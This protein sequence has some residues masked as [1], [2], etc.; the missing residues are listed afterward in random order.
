MTLRSLQWDRSKLNKL[1]ITDKHSNIF[2]L[3][4]DKVTYGRNYKVNISRAMSIGAYILKNNSEMRLYNKHILIIARTDDTNTKHTHRRTSLYLNYCNGMY[5]Y[6]YLDTFLLLVNGDLEVVVLIIDNSSAHF[7]RRQ[8]LSWHCST[9][10][11]PI[12]YNLVKV[13]K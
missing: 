6:L 11:G 9:V 10:I 13:S 2:V 5:A 4:V 7:T 8:Q 1:N 3:C 12:Y